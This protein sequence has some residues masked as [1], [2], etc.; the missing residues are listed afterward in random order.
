MDPD[1][2]RAM[3]WIIGVFGAIALIATT[4]LFFGFRALEKPGSRK[5]LIL[6]GACVAFILLVCVGLFVWSLAA[7][8]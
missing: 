7:A 2:Q 1:F 6:L 5:A 3:F 8:R 4:V